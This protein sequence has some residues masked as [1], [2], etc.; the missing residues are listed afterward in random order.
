MENFIKQFLQKKGYVVNDDAMTVI[1]ACDDWYANR[2]VKEFHNRETVQGVKYELNR[3]NFAKRCCSDDANL[4]EVL[5]INAGSGEQADFV[6]KML[7]ESE[8]NTQYRKQLEKTSADGTT[9]CYIRLDN[10]TL[11]DNGRAKDGDIKLNYV[12]ADAFTPLTVENDIVIEAAFS[13]ITLRAGKKQTTLVL[14]Q[15]N[16]NGVYT[17]ETHMFDD[18]GNEIKEQE[19]AVILGNVKPFAV[20]RNAE[21]NNLDDM[22]GYGL[23]KL[24][25]AVPMLKAVDLCYNVLFSDLDKA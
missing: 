10:A 1:G 24:W 18:K 3:L 15:K 4:C 8:F 22:T 16:K 23:P 25:N 2:H 5:E 14:F 6:N 12:D 21:V 11:L 17:A 19:T 13:G 20:M 7:A 9:A